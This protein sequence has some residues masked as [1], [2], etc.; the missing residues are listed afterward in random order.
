M[1]FRFRKVITEE[2]KEVV[3]E[4]IKKQTWGRRTGKMSVSG[5]LEDEASL[6]F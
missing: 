1:R 6:R 3:K 2:A 4:Q 5:G